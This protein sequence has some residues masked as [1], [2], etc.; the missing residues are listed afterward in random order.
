MFKE[1]SQPL[2]KTNPA[3]A[4]AR[5]YP[6]LLEDGDNFACV[7]VIPGGGYAHCSHQ[8]GPPVAAWFNSMGISAVVLEYSVSN[9]EG[10]DTY[11][12]PQQQALY[13]MR[14]LRA[15]ATQLNINPSKIGVIGF[16]AGGHLAACVSNGFD[17]EE[18]LLDPDGCLEGVSARPDAAILSYAVLSAGTE[19][20]HRGSMENLLGERNNSQIQKQLCWEKNVHSNSPETF[21][22]HTAEDNVV[23][24]ENSYQMGIALQKASIS[25]ELHVF[26]KGQHGIGLGSIHTRRQGSAEQWRPLAERWLRERGF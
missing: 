24:V 26:P 15:N 21:L 11:P 13:A 20:A 4:T 17:R 22:W 9:D 10:A 3:L 16:S 7:L 19:Y 25:H 2:H 1:T 12:K 23:P 6:Y 5:L 18:W 8:E 14:W